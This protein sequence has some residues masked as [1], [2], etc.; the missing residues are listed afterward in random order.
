VTLVVVVAVTAAVLWAAAVAVAH[1]PVRSRSPKSGATAPQALRVVSV[2]FKSRIAGGSLTVRRGGRQVSAGRGVASRR[3]LR[4]TL[5]GSVA[6]GTYRAS[7][8]IVAADGHVQQGSWRFRV[9]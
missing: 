3:M 9:R 4:A 8:R 6:P 1:S 7:W 5:T 2:T